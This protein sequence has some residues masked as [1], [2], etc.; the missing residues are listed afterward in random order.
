MAGVDH[1]GVVEPADMVDRVTV[2][3]SLTDPAATASRSSM[4]K[5]RWWAAITIVLYALMGMA[6]NWPTLPGDGRS[7]RQGD[8]TQMAWYLAWTPHALSNG[9]NPFHTTA[10][11]YPEGVNLAQNTSAPVLGLL[12]APLTLA[13]NPVASLNL[14]LWLAFPLSAA[15]MYFVL[16]RFG[17]WPPAAFLGGALYGFS[18]HVVNQSFNH[19]NLAFVPLPPLMLLALYE[20]LRP[21]NPRVI[22]WGVALACLSTAQFFISAEV[23]ATTALT[24]LLATVII[25]CSRPRQVI[26]A[27][28]RSLVAMGVAFAIM[29][30]FVVYPAWFM[31]NGL[32]TYDGPAYAGGIS[33]DLMGT[34][35]P[36]M[37]LRF[38]TDEAMARGNALAN[39]NVPENGSYLGIPLIALIVL[40][41]VVCWSVQWVRLSAAMVVLLTILSWGPDVMIHNKPAG[42]TIPFAKLR[43]LPFLDNILV[44]RLSLQVSIFVAIIVAAGLTDIWRRLSSVSASGVSTAASTGRVALAGTTVAL[45]IASVVTLVPRWPFETSPTAVP[46]YFSSSAVDHV[47]E[48]SVVLITPYPSVMDVRPQLWQATSGIR[49]R[50]LGGY[51]LTPDP[52]G[53]PTNFPAVL[54]PHRVQ[55]YL[56]AMSSG[57]G[58][59]RY[60]EG[61]VP[62]FGPR[63]VCDFQTFVLANNITTVLAATVA[64]NATEL[65]QLYVSALGPPSESVGGVDAWYGIKRAANWCNK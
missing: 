17:A 36:T 3:T 56:T 1:P 34:V 14:L 53:Q 59:Y 54:T 57:A 6:A 45:V 51:A 18:P 2:E 55:T 46:E 64:A 28:R 35:A 12:T 30:A 32:H 16:R 7:M 39:G 44:I 33:A 42:F 48:D 50:M 38:H 49:F 13:V 8:M 15:A 63:L 52:R 25:A 11:N 19:L 41:V 60:P 62:A 24:G 43:E 27:I 10:L 31:L 65:R 47:P 21:G 22:R 29:A 40:I 4:A 23:A 5:A 58:G 26:P 20:T 61:P 37:N 9:N